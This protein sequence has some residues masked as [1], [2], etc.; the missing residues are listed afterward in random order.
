MFGKFAG[1]A[2][3][4]RRR[5]RRR[6]YRFCG[7][8]RHSIERHASGR[9]NSGTHEIA[10]GRTPARL[11]RSL[12]NRNKNLRVYEPHDSCRS[13][14]KMAHRH[15]SRFIAARVS[16]S[17]RNKP[18]F[19]R[20]LARTLPRRLRQTKPHEHYPERNDLHGLACDSYLLQRKRSCRPS[21]RNFTDKRIK[22]LGGFVSGQIQQ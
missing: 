9:R 14:R 19:S 17:G 5:A 20:R 2:A 13:A 18:A 15:F 1:H 22:R 12:G 11:G 6:F 21:L 8:S 10:Y 16:N 7:L 3:F 4:I